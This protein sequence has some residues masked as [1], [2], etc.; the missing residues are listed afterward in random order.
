METGLNVRPVQT[1]SP[2]PV[3]IAAAPERQVT[4][5]ELPETQV[6]TAP[7]VAA[8]VSVEIGERESHLRAE[9]NAAIDARSTAPVAAEYQSRVSI[10]EASKEVVFTK[11]SASTGNVVQQYPDDAILRQ[12]AYQAQELKAVLA[13]ATGGAGIRVA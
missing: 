4:Q 7:A 13:A 9:L 5:T 11:V 1:S 12:R 8:P 10:D 2:A 6:V 3:R